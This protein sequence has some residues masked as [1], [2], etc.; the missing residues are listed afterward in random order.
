METASGNGGS[1]RRQRLLK[2]GSVVAISA[3]VIG[4]LGWLLTPRLTEHL[5][6]NQLER[7]EE[8]AGVDLD[9]DV[10]RTAG[11]DRIEIRDFDVT[12]ADGDEPLG[13]IDAID[14]TVDLS[15]ALRGHP[16]ISSIDLRGVDFSLQR[17]ADGTSELDDIRRAIAGDQD[18]DDEVEDT[19]EEA[20]LDDLVERLLRHF[21][22]NYPDVHV[23][24]ASLELLSD[25]GAADWPVRRLATDELTVVSGGDNAT[26]ETAIDLTASNHPDLTTP[27]RIVASGQLRR[28]VD[29]S[30]VAID[31][32]P[33]V[34]L[35]NFG[36]FP[37][38]EIAVE[39]VEIADDYTLE[40]TAPSID[41]RFP[42]GAERLAAADRLRLQFD[43]WPRSRTDLAVHDVEIAS[44]RLFIEF[45]ENGGSN[46]F[47]LF[48]VTRQPSAQ[49]VATT[50]R[51]IGHDI[52]LANA[53]ADDEDENDDQLDDA[54][55][56]E[57]DIVDRIT[58]LPIRDWFVEYVPHRTK[59]DDFRLV[60]DDRR[61][62]DQLT[63]PA[64]HFEISGDVFELHHR[65]LRGVIEGEIRLRTETDDETGKLDLDFH[66]PYR[67]GNWNA[68]VKVDNLELAHFAQLGGSR[69]AEHLH[70]GRIVASI[71]VEHDGRDDDA[72]TRFDGLINPRDTRVFF[73]G[74][75]DD[76]IEVAAASLMF[77]GYYDPTG[78]I[79]PADLISVAEE[80]DDEDEDDDSD[81]PPDTGAFVVE[82][83][84]ARLADAE[85]EINVGLYGIDGLRLPSRVDL[86][87]ELEP[88]EL[89]TLVDA[90]P[91]AL[92]GP[93]DGI[94]LLGSLYWDFDLE[95]P[96]YE[97]SN[98]AWDAHVDL[99]PELEVVEIPEEVDVFGLTDEFEHT[100]VDDWEQEVE[101]QDR[102]FFY[103][104]TIEIPEMKPTPATWL[105]DNTS[106]DLEQI[107]EI[108]REREWPEVPE[109]DESL[110]LTPE[111][112]EEPEY[113]L[114]DLALAESADVPWDDEDDGDDGGWWSD[115]ASGGDDAVDDEEDELV[116]E[117]P[118]PL[119]FHE[120]EIEVDPD[121]YGPYVY[122]P[123]HHISPY[124]VRA[125]KTTEDNSFF[126]H[127]G[128]NFLAIR[129]SV[130]Q[131]LDAGRYVR[132]ASTISMQLAKNLFLERDRVLSR[133][134][135]EVTLVWLIESVAEI[136]KARMMELYLN[137]IEFG[138]GIYGVHEAAMH[139]FGKRPDALT[140]DEA[141]WLVSIVP[142]PKHYH[143]H[144]DRGEITPGWFHR[145]TRYIRA[146]EARERISE[147]EKE[148]AIEEKPVFY[149]PEDGE[150][151]LRADVEDVDPDREMDDDEEVD[152]E[153][154]L[155][156]PTFD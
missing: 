107:D 143:S 99:S 93:L 31:F 126:T 79:P 130:E 41:S 112:L 69:V 19:D 87:V 105:I 138:P 42:N 131:N 47:D 37:F 16:A 17:R 98:M 68:A 94:E 135:Q 84:T 66:I 35:A 53:D 97:A 73:A 121:R 151:L 74:V 110:G 115:W 156:L 2:A 48:A 39:G 18:D 33:E 132:G 81:R 9:A 100:I 114:T 78:E 91:A 22:G 7:V 27:D 11:F 113:W 90:V 62:H 26:F 13:T 29:K 28:P 153:P 136:P 155:E 49:R 140:I 6:T 59:I 102:E 65:P 5:L 50:A 55:A 54:P 83:A 34:R 32:D 72:R 89:Q 70:G 56:V 67:T 129:Q 116:Y 51:T 3:L 71:D 92:R 77:N 63:S 38:A 24:D 148:E 46:I 152:E 149:L 108:R 104:R 60:V 118:E 144:Y 142:N 76:P 45:D 122:V 30:T 141:A 52:A 61:D 88:T 139:Y 36:Q 57:P 10:L 75:A 119:E 4:L 133:K 40:V 120:L 14:A 145:M 146:M 127:A 1:N 123:L 150:P 20:D 58:A 101:Y 23:V 21:G 103:E 95:I 86:G 80:S 117:E 128:F 15:S 154:T 134:L 8:R 85:A 106:L 12:V 111:Q 125:I 43:Y 96:L 137:I 82:K 64:D 109:W 44:P 25:D 124:L 147:E